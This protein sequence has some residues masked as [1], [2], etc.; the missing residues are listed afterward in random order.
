M[1]ACYL[2][3][4]TRMFGLSHGGEKRVCHIVTNITWTRLTP[5][6]PPALSPMSLTLAGVEADTVATSTKTTP[7]ST[8]D[9]VQRPGPVFLDRQQVADMRQALAD[10]GLGE[11]SKEGD[12]PQ[13]GTSQ[14]ERTLADMVRVSSC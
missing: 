12:E 14:K 3:V 8:A 13:Q 6:P 9:D 2:D 4:Y 10:M 11:L 1:R 7:E 5:T